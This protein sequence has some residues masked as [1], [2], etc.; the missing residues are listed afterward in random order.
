VDE[1]QRFF[2]PD[3]EERER[4]VRIMDLLERY[5][6]AVGDYLPAKGK[7]DTL[8]ELRANLMAEMEGREEELGRP[9]NEAEVS[10]VLERHGRPV[11]VASRYLPRYYLIGPGLFPL[12][13]FT[14]LKSFPLMVLAYA[15]AQ[16]V[17]FLFGGG[18]AANIGTAIARF[19]SVAFTFWGVVTLGFAVFEYAQGRYIE[20]IKW[21]KAWDPRDLPERTER[22][23]PSFASRV[24]DL[25]VHAL[26]VLWL[27]AVPD[28]PYLVLGPGASLERLSLGLA[29]DWRV[30]YW[31][32]V[33]LLVLMLALKAAALFTTA[34]LRRGVELTTQAIGIFILVVMVQA[35]SYFAPLREGSNLLSRTNLASINYSVNLAFKIAL[36]VSVVKFLWDLWQA[37]A[38]SRVKAAGFVRVF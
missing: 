27:L 17:G 34:K 4:E 23:G 14:L 20:Q 3:F 11:I 37:L 9:L 19:P 36:A 7:L 29:P 31:Q 16:G 18:S 26:G 35:R 21:T 6:Q 5:F 10:A 30:F 8:A 22:K 1:N 13:W 38:G 28:H 32:L 25:I 12:Y 24:A 15:A 2:A 33:G